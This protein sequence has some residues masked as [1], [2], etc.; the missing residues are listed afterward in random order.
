M[1]LVHLYKDFHCS[2]AVAEKYGIE[3]AMFI[4]YILERMNYYASGYPDTAAK[5]RDD[6]LWF[7]PATIEAISQHFSGLFSR[8]TV[9]RIT[10]KLEADGIVIAKK[11][12]NARRSPGDKWYPADHTKRYTVDLKKLEALHPS[13]DIPSISSIL[14]S[15]GQF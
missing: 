10:Q 3:G 11:K 6:G 8:R 2:K 1:R 9:M 15:K 7:V 4:N 14:N 13:T 12:L 5:Y